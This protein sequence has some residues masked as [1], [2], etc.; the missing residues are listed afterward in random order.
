MSEPDVDEY[1]AALDEPKRGTLERLRKTILELVPEAE[2]CMSYGLP[3]FRLD[4]K[5]VAGFGAFK[6]HLSYFPHSGS[7]HPELGMT[8]LGTPPQRER[9]S[10]MSTSLFRRRS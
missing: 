6:N 1:L 10:S 5:V 7:V 9:C 8:S 3:A 4:G 2:Q